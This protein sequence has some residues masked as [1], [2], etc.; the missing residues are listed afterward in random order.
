[1]KWELDTVVDRR[2]AYNHYF[3]KPAPKKS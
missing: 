1:V 2:M 3:N